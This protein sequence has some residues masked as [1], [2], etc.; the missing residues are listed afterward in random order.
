MELP[1]E[2]V[3]AGLQWI[4]LQNNSLAGGL[5]KPS[6][7]QH[8]WAVFSPHVSVWHSLRAALQAAPVSRAPDCFK[9]PQQAVGASW[10]QVLACST[11]MFFGLWFF[12][13]FSVS[14]YRGAVEISTL[15]SSLCSEE[16]TA[17]LM[18]GHHSGSD[19]TLL[20]TGGS[21]LLD[22]MPCKQGAVSVFH[23]VAEERRQGL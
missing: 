18:A 22:I 14:F 7:P 13:V 10:M 9:I 6:L 1:L 4:S 21:T 3:Q 2:E 23:C 11:E 5:H 15:K 19:N 20:A 16:L 8:W 17:G 12:S